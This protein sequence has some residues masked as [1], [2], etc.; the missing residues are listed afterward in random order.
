MKKDE[1]IEEMLKDMG[2]RN[3]TIDINAYGKGLI[4]M[5]D[6]L[7]KNCYTPNVSGRSEELRST[8]DW[9]NGNNSPHANNYL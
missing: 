6:K 2:D 8:C 7:V 9:C 5:Y 1:L 3:N 4:D